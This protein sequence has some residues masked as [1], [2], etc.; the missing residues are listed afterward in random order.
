MV[1]LTRGLHVSAKLAWRGLGVLLALAWF[2]IFVAM[3]V[4]IHTQPSRSAELRPAET[5]LL[6]RM[7]YAEARGDGLLGMAGVSHV[8]VNRLKQ[9]Q[10]FGRTLRE[11]LL[12]RRQFAVGPAR[13]QSDRSWKLALW[14]ADGVLAGTLPDLTFGAQ[15]F[16]RCDMK[17]KPRWTRR[18]TMTVKIHRHCFWRRP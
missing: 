7:A 9:P 5:E 17:P 6:A 4:V 8:A 16:H 10:I 15:Y 2:A 12:A 11:V 14:V 3:M 13:R 1:A 18:M